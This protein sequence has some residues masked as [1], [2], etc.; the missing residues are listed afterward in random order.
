MEYQWQLLQLVL[1]QLLQ[2]DEPEEGVKPPS[3]L[4]NP[5]ADMRRFTSCP[6]H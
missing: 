1:E 4:L 5:Q 2:P 6:L 3:A